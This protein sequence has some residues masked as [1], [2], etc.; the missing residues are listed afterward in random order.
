MMEQAVEDR[1]GD[2]VSPKTSPQAPRLWL[3]V[4]MIEPR[5]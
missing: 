3:L 5:S 2:T 1:A 4:M